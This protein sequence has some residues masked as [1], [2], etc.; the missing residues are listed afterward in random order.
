MEIKV[1]KLTN[2]RLL[3][4]ANEMTT[5]KESRMSLLGCYRAMHSNAR[6]QIFWIRMYN[7]PLFVASHLVRHVHAQPYQRSKRLDRDPNAKDLGRNTPT[8][9]ALL[10]NAEEIVNI[11][12]KRLC[13]K[14]SIETREIWEQGLHEISKVDPDLVKFCIK[15]CV[16]NGGICRE[17]KGC[18]F[19]RSEMCAKRIE[20]YRK[21]FV[22]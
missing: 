1:E 20:E 19:N 22:V 13:T 14:A 15:P 9:L 11:S 10:V 21:L 4:E 7:I 12:F 17:P 3:H 16:A 6:T 18:G 5:G 2:E 8:D